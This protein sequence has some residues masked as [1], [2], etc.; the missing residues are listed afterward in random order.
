MRKL[1]I[2]IIMAAVLLI[3]GSLAWNA[4]ATPVTGFTNAAQLGTHGSL[5]EK[6]ACR[7]AGFF[8]PAGQQRVCRGRLGMC[9]CVPCGHHH[10]FCPCPGHVCKIG[11]RW[12]DCTHV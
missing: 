11:G 5:V 3:T 1:S 7:S 2:G 6:A 12:Y 8:C 9:V 10:G 4:G